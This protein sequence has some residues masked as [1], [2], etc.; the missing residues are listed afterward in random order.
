MP[1]EGIKQVWIV[2]HHA[3]L[4]SKDGGSARHLDLSE[5]LPSLGW[6]STLIVA[7]TRHSNGSQAL[8]GSSLRKLTVENGVRTLWVRTNSYGTSLPL[9]FI[10]MVLFALNLLRP[11]TTRGI[12]KPDVIV[13][14]TVHPVAAWAGY[15]LSLRHKVP[16]V[17]EIRDV[18]PESLYEMANIGP[19]SPISLALSR[20]DRSLIRRAALVIS[21][22]PYVDRHLA[23][24]GYPEKPFMWIANG[25]ELPAN[26]DELP[27]D[28]GGPFTYMYLGAH[29]RANALED[30]LDA[31]DAACTSAPD[32]DLR[33]RL[34]GDG[35]LKNHLKAHAAALINGNR[36]SF[37][38]R[39]PK[40]EV[41]DRAGEADC[42]IANLRD[43]PVY[44]FGVSLNKY[45]MYMAA[46]RPVLSA[47]SA[48]N[49][50]IEDSRAGMVV[51]AG[52][53]EALSTAIKQ[54]ARLPH[55][56]RAE[57]AA[58]GRRE[59]EK[60]YTFDVLSRKLADGLDWVISCPS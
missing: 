24:V 36:I 8:R 50:P 29:G 43:M 38:D 57:F 32:L 20:I 23:E 22:L 4:P 35:P 3:V 49:N 56:V 52:D 12:V 40:S 16:F 25:S 21:P 48:P 33:L 6:N 41:L 15:R 27:R 11:G 51:P 45:F 9:R 10:G 37:E 42:L 44:R 13:G 53:T 7:S 26:V 59:L 58:N 55:S 46:G 39:I 47:S 17:Y 19:R 2:N 60:S 30:V 34:V 28:K 18:W 1:V 14:S 31:F 54:L 5:R